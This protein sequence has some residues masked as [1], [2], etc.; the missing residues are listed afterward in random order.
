MSTREML[1]KEKKNKAK[2][3]FLKSKHREELSPLNETL[4]VCL[5]PL[6]HSQASFRTLR[7]DAPPLSEEDMLHPSRF[8]F[9][10]SSFFSASPFIS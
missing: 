4:S 1:P 2:W 7:F 3:N 5:A 10:Y 9:F 6:F 8:I